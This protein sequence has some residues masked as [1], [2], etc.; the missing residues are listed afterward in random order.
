MRMTRPL[1]LAILVMYAALTASEAHAEP[2]TILLKYVQALAKGNTGGL[3]EL[4]TTQQYKTIVDDTGGISKDFKFLGEYGN[5]ENALLL[6]TQK[7]SDFTAYVAE[8]AQ[9]NG[10]TNWLFRLDPKGE[11]IANAAILSAQRSSLKELISSIKISSFAV[12]VGDG[13]ST[14]SPHPDIKTCGP[15]CDLL[16]RSKI[17]SADSR[18]VDFLFATDRKPGPDQNGASFIGFRNP[19]LTFGA[20]TVRIPE[21]HGIGNVEL[22][23]TWKIFSFEIYREKQND[24]KHFSLKRAA[25]IAEEDFGALI[26]EQNQKSA[27]IFVHGFNNSFEDAVYR[28]AQ[29]LWDLK[30]KGVAVLYAWSAKGSGVS[31]YGFDRSALFARDGFIKLVQKLQNDLGIERIDVLAHSMGNL[32]V[33]DA[34]GTNV[35][36]AKPVQLDQLVMAAPDIERESFKKAIPAL[37]KITKG[38]TLYASSSD[39]ALLASSTIQKFPRAGEVPPEGPVSLPDLDTIDVSKLGD[40]FLGLNHATFAENRAIMDDLKLLLFHRLKS[41]RLSQIHPF[42]EP[43]QAMRYWRYE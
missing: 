33:I 23:S 8:V 2:T 27:L 25:F 35:L 15:S 41:P 18:E 31:D 38:M 14:D 36:T 11:K 43:P 9:A 26:R 24:K 21:G 19:T 13:R 12:A 5:A 40:E 42:P 34:L 6:K 10:K 20:V 30:Y 4:T 28:N 3:K 1:L 37:K 7:Y 29:M 16:V 22:P 32:V 17:G 39:K